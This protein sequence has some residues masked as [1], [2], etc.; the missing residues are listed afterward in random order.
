M[1]NIRVPVL[2]LLV[3]FASTAASQW[4][5]EAA[6]TLRLRGIIEKYEPTTRI[7]S[8]TTP[9]GTVRFAL[10]RSARI[11]QGWHALDVSALGKMSG[12]RVDVRY[13]DSGGEKTVESVHVDGKPKG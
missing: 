12:Y 5:A 8:V 7:L 3:S 2:L 6:T 11:R 4:P 13:S 10:P 9:T 1:S